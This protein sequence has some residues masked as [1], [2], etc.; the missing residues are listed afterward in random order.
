MQIKRLSTLFL[1]LTSIWIGWTVLVDMVIVPTV[2]RI[3]PNFFNAG[4]LGIALFSK[5]NQ[6]EVV[7]AT[8]NIV[9]LAFAL[10]KRK[11]VLPL[12][13]LSILSFSIVMF[14]FSY[15]TPMITHLTDVWKQS[16]L[17]GIYNVPGIGDIQ[18]AHQKYHRIYVGMDVLKLLILCFIWAMAFFQEEKWN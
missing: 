11:K 12:L 3:V 5:L 6:F 7:V 15:L 8:L 13:M 10:Q 16:D 4:D 17:A 14:Y 9:I 1:S 2:F 18:Q